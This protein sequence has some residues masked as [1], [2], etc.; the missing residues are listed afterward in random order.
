MGELIPIKQGDATPAEA[1]MTL[2]TAFQIAAIWSIVLA[3]LCYLG[4]P[5]AKAYIASATIVAAIRDERLHIGELTAAD[6][7]AANMVV[8]AVEQIWL[9]N[10]AKRRI[11]YPDSVTDVQI[12][13]ALFIEHL[14][15]NEIAN[16][17]SGHWRGPENR[18]PTGK[19]DIS[20]KTLQER[21]YRALKAVDDA[22][23]GYCVGCDRPPHLSNVY[24]IIKGKKRLDRLEV[25]PATKREWRLPELP[26]RWKP[27]PL[28]TWAHLN[29]TRQR[30]ENKAEK[31]RLAERLVAEYQAAGGTVTKLPAQKDNPWG[32]GHAQFQKP[33]KIPDIHQYEVENL[34][35]NGNAWRYGIKKPEAKP[36]N[37]GPTAVDEQLKMAA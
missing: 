13:D 34:L 6:I 32:S 20:L 24:T 29:A 27:A 5:A 15:E 4:G 23:A 18:R 35:S 19:Y 36:L 16:D 26:A 7:A 31:H 22:F 17:P 11:R 10:D 8:G 9:A 3:E 37:D 21:R 14:S 30:P 2:R 28:D 12:M 1:A 33:P 25:V